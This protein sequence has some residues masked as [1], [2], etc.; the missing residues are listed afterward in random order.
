MKTN[1][2][3]VTSKFVTGLPP[4]LYL[5]SIAKETSIKVKISSKDFYKVPVSFR[6]LSSNP[7]SIVNID[8]N[9]FIYVAGNI[10]KIKLPVMPRHYW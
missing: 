6:K 1:L 2:V 5:Q 8:R 7:F 10:G 9:R 3:F 4:V